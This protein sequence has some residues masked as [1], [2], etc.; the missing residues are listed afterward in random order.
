MPKDFSAVRRSFAR[1][2]CHIGT[3]WYIEDYLHKLK[4]TGRKPRIDVGDGQI[5]RTMNGLTERCSACSTI[6]GQV[7][8][9]LAAVPVKESIAPTN[10]VPL[11]D[12]P[13]V[14]HDDPGRSLGVSGP[15]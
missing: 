6:P 4:S 3:S 11:A 5:L 2:R 7:G 1:F 10:S 8:L 13:R 14:A 12:S 9:D 15:D